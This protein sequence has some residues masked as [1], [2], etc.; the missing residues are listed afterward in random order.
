MPSCGAVVGKSGDGLGKVSDLS[1]SSTRLSKYLTYQVFFIRSFTSCFSV[2]L[3]N[4]S[5]A[6]NHLVLMVF[7]PNPQ[8]LIRKQF[9]K[10]FIIV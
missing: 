4:L 6:S 9:N 10:G 2:F 5:T 8:A 1:T 7:P 3:R